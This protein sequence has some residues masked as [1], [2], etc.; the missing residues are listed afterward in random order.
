MNNVDPTGKVFDTVWDIGNE[1]RSRN[2]KETINILIRN[3]NIIMNDSDILFDQIILELTSDVFFVDF[4]FRK[5]D[6]SF[7]R[8]TALGK[9]IIML[10]HWIDGYN[11]IIYPQYLVRY[12]SLRKW[13][14][15]FSFK[16]KRDQRDGVYVGFSGE[17]LGS[18]DKYSFELNK[19]NYLIEI[20]RLRTCLKSNG[21]L[22][23][24]AY[25]SLEKAYNLEIEPI[26]DGI[27]ELPDIGADWFFENLT[28]CRLVHPENYERLKEIHLK[29]ARYMYDRGEPNITAYYDKL[30][31]IL[32][33]LE[34][35]DLKG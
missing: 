3:K 2:L 24:N 7:C 25:S 35:L 19:S 21:T 8:K 10:D 27:K 34:N 29:Q 11:L 1:A 23:F 5:R 30:D 26:F 15:K 28:L 31:E 4:R 22:V 33:Y 16:T 18:Q 20:N 9:D 17:L 6:N 14:E 12:D 13:F 32:T